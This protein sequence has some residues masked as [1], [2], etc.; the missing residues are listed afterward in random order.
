MA[1]FNK[2]SNTPQDEG[3][4][5]EDQ[6]SVE[7]KENPLASSTCNI[8]QPFGPSSTLESDVS[9]KS[10][11]MIDNDKAMHATSAECKGRHLSYIY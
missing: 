5:I 7:N 11:N 8:E 2:G 10:E 1:S 9:F 6:S 3:A 4:K